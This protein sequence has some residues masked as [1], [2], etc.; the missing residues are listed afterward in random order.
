[1]T[2][3]SVL[4]AIVAHKQQELLLTQ[5]ATPIATLMANTEPCQIPR[6]F[7][8]VLRATDRPYHLITEIKPASPSAGALANLAQGDPFN[9]VPLI[10]RYNPVASGFSVLTDARYFGGSMALLR[11]VVGLT[12]H[13]VLRKDFIVNPYQVVEARHAGAEA[14]LLI[15]KSL[16]DATLA[17]LHTKTLHWGMTPVVEV[18]NEAE[19]VRLAPLEPT[20]VLINNRNLDTLAIDRSTTARLAPLVPSGWHIVSAS[21]IATAQDVAELKPFANTFLLGTAL[22]KAHQAGTLETLLTH[23]TQGSPL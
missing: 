20:V 21:G 7:E 15:V 12:P 1:M 17:A 5:A 9:P 8:A 10:E 11:Q 3:P 14:V 13:P 18:N 22:M 19:L 16:D 23:L 6:R 4:Q 2:Q